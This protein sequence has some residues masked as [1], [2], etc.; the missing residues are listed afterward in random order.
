[1]IFSCFEYN[2]QTYKYYDDD[3]SG[4]RKLLGRGTRPI[5][6][7]YPCDPIGDVDPATAATLGLGAVVVVGGLFVV[8]PVVLL[9]WAVK[10]A[11]G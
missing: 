8:L 4:G 3:P 2:T 10:K 5:G 11:G 1:M 7:V 6:Q 9:Y